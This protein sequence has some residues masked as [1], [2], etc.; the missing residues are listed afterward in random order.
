MVLREF[1]L[2]SRRFVQ[3]GFQLAEA[4][5]GAT[6]LDRDTLLLASAGQGAT[7]SGYANTVRLWAR[8]EAPSEPLFQVGETSMGAD[9]HYDRGERPAAVH[10][11]RRFL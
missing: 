1:D 3:D 8:G 6:W 4:K 2:G 7:N 10:R 5:G 11:I 9:G